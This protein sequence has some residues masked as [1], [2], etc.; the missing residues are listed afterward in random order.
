MIK[1]YLDDY[2]INL[3][4]IQIIEKTLADKLPKDLTNELKKYKDAILLDRYFSQLLS[5]EVHE[6]TEKMALRLI[7]IKELDKEE[8][9]VK[10]SFKNATNIFDEYK[11]L[12]T[13]RKVREKVTCAIKTMNNNILISL[14]ILF[15]KT[16]ASLLKHIVEKYPSAYL[17]ERKIDYTDILKRKDI[18]EVK[19]EIIREQVDELMRESIFSII[20]TLNRKHQL[21]IDYKNTYVK[22]F[23]EAYLR[24]NIVVH[25]DGVINKD[26]IEGMKKIGESVSEEEIGIRVLSNKE[27]IDGIIEATTYMIIYVLYMSSKIFEDEK[28]DFI[29]SLMNIGYEKIQKGEYDFTK[30]LFA[31]IK[32]DPNITEEFRIY[33]KINY[34]QSYKWAGKYNE[35][36]AEVENFDESPYDLVIKLAIY[37]LRE[38]YAPIEYILYNEFNDERQNESLAIRLED[39]PVFQKLRE[40]E[41]YK[42]IQESHREIFE[43]RL[44]LIEE[45]TEKETKELE[46]QFSD[47]F[48]VKIKI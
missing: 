6:K 41:F 1:K 13:S 37:S 21:N 33:S 18:D 47:G 32:D 35:I 2:M 34:W 31:L 25:N 8:Q 36:E 15:E 10:Y 39:F 44:S 5:G 30:E 7:D 14:I 23:I 9:T 17:N 11:D 27:Y 42:Q 46:E 45:E 12:E 38:E 48:S 3:E 4:G 20:N 29:N 22:R 24:R 16:L 19:T 26:Y 43:S 40:Q 28:Q